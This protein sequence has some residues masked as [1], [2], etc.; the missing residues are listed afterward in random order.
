M[1]FA[2]LHFRETAGLTYRNLE[3]LSPRAAE[4]TF[5]SYGAYGKTCNLDGG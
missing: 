3:P 5:G 1:K 4:M 2:K